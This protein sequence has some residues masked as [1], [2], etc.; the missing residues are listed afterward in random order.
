MRHGGRAEGVGLNQVC[1]SG[2]IALV[3]VADHI[4][5]G[6]TEQLVIALDVACKVLKALARCARAAVA[7][8]PVL[9]FPQLE[10]LD[11]GAQ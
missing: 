6:E 5:P 7:L 4:R 9:G 10:A 3:D 8:A 1:A 2:Q 11:H